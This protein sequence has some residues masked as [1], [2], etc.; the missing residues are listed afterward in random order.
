MND[1][2]SLSSQ[3]LE[4]DATW[5]ATETL[6]L[7]SAGTFRDPVYDSFTGSSTGDI[8]ATASSGIPETATSTSAT[9]ILDVKNLAAS[10]RAD[11]QYESPVDYFDAVG[12]GFTG[13]D[14]NTLLGY[15]KEISTIKASAGF[16]TE[17]RLGV[18]FRGRN[19]FDD[20]YITTP[21]PGAA[22]ARTLSGYPS[23]P[24]TYGVT[25]RKSF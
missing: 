16:T 11:W 24:P 1:E 6:V 2:K 25:I 8:S 15:E 19:I 3:G 12:T 14:N 7:T 18:T 17:N 23:A 4:V 13:T 9:H 10:L 5:N 21:F 22:Q 20:Q